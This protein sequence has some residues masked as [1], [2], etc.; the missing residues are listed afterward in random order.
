IAYARGAAGL[1]ASLGLVLGAFRMRRDYFHEVLPWLSSKGVLV[2]FGCM[3]SA[4]LAYLALERLLR[5]FLCQPQG[6]WLLQPWGTPFGFVSLLSLL[7]TAAAFAHGTPTTLQDRN[8]VAR[9]AAAKGAG[10]M[11]VV[12]VDTLRADHLPVYGYAHGHTPALDR[13]SQDAIR[14][15]SAFANASWTRPSFASILTGRFASSH[16]TMAKNDA[17]P[18]EITTL[19][20]ALRDGGYHTMGV[21][22]N[23][24]V[25]PFFNF[26]QGFDLYTYL[27]PK[28]VLGASDSAAKL[29]LVQSL[30]Q[31]IETARAKQGRVE[32]GT[33]YQ[34]AAAVNHAALQLIYNHPKVT[35]AP[36]FAFVAYMDP[37]DPYYPHPY[38]GTGYSRA[39]H[40]NPKPEEVD[41][42]I[43]LYDGEITYWDEHF[44]ALMNVLRQ[45]G[46][47]DDMTI[48]VTADHGEEFMDHGGFWHGTTLYDEAL[49]VP[50]LVKLPKN[51]Q[52]GSVVRHFVQSVDLMPSL[53]R[54]A[55]VPVPAGVQGQDLFSGHDNVFAEESHEGNVLTALRW[56]R[57]GS[58]LK[59]IHANKGNPRGLPET[60]LYQV[61]R[62][63]LELVD[64]ASEEPELMQLTEQALRAQQE[65]AEQGRAARRSVNLADDTA[66]AERLRALGYAG[67]SKR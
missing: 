65:A 16:R 9:P 32:P 12:V 48:V 20:E 33:A 11:L 66:A 52:H 51:L 19:P 46:L 14:F 57:A 29:L 54:L 23:Y 27:E 15:E 64:L 17:L 6:A 39:A 67:G 37:H 3:V 5:W 50:L 61:D 42:L 13:F 45:S 38:N 31:A 40:P 58:A 28:F 10:N 55:G 22:T 56:L 4:A 21:V 24:N 60:E 63:P 59:L 44:G 43:P 49:H 7:L 18:D 1:A 2:L 62:D 25:A 36:F 34:D 53:L 35:Q 8:F 47:Y 41:Q 30:R 26:H